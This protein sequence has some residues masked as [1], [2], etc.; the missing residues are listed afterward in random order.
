VNFQT[1]ECDTECTTC[2]Q[3]IQQERIGGITLKAGPIFGINLISLP[4]R[5]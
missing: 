5:H 1:A 4:K 2:L 3:V